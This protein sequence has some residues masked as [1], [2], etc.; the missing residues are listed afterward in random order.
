LEHPE[1]TNAA[2][3]ARRFRRRIKQ[4]AVIGNDG[5]AML[6]RGQLGREPTILDRRELDVLTLMADGRRRDEIAERLG[7]TTRSLRELRRGLMAKLGART[8]QHA[9]AIAFRR[10]LLHVDRRGTGSSS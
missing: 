4:R 3:T 8:D 1:T 2:S 6:A 9:T 10:G 5:S 7:L